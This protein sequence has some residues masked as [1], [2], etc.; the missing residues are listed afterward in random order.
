MAFTRD[1]T[2]MI[3][4]RTTGQKLN[5]QLLDKDSQMN[6]VYN[7]KTVAEM[8]SNSKPKIG[9][10][11]NTYGFYSF[12][13]GGRAKYQVV[14]NTGVTGN[15][16]TLFDLP[17]TLQAK[18][19]HNGSIRAEQIGIKGG[20]NFNN[21]PFVIAAIKEGIKDIYFRSVE[22]QFDELLIS[23]PST[24]VTNI[25]LKLHGG[26]ELT[27]NEGGFKSTLFTP[28]RTGQKFIVKFGGDA[29]FTTATDALTWDV[30]NCGLINIAL[31]DSGKP[32]T[33]A[34]LALEYVYSSVF[35]I[36]L[37]NLASRGLYIKNVW[38]LEFTKLIVRYSAKNTSCVYIDTPLSDGVSNTSSSIFKE[39][40]LE[41]LYNVFLETSQNPIL[42]NI[43][44]DNIT[45]EYAMGD[46]TIVNST[47]TDLTTF[48]NLTKIPLFR[49]GNVDGLTIGQMNLSGVSK[50]SY[51]DGVNNIVDSIF[52]FKDF[53]NVTVG[54]IN[55]N[56]SGAFVKLAS[57]AGANLS[58][59]KVNSV[60]SSLKNRL[61][62][63]Q[64]TTNL[65]MLSD[66]TK[67]GVVIVNN[68]FKEKDD[69]Q[70]AVPGK[71]Y[72]KEELLK[73]CSATKTDYTL[74]YDALSVNGY[75][76]GRTA[77]S[78]QGL[79][80]WKLTSATLKMRVRIKT[81]NTSLQINY[82]DSSGAS[83]TTDTLPITGNA[84][85]YQEFDF[86]ITKGTN[87]D[88][89]RFIVPQAGTVCNVDYVYF[90]L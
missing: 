40:Y 1:F 70:Y 75:V 8:K 54:L 28:F 33:N 36:G 50:R 27:Y 81:D 42:G 16:I 49:L 6:G 58:I 30:Y 90:Y 18:L 47:I 20:E 43:V 32:T 17:N 7:N 38:E 65:V 84:S 57:G 76:F 10:I 37:F 79:F 11:I 67:G 44:I 61:Y 3:V 68:S 46:Y 87:V 52:E 34:C 14:A 89:F 13:D 51:N 5:E 2:D 74:L 59:L 82:Q 85:A 63:A 19:L 60:T 73:L 24:N 31:S 48:N 56:D 39:I 80:K 22:Y 64:T 72:N 69:L 15:D 62:N 86:T 35:S 83:L 88:S 12:G 45:Y 21:T 29:N 53:F 78:F 71:L 41:S 55:I 9:N 4:D 26:S 23:Y 66:V 77:L 25:N